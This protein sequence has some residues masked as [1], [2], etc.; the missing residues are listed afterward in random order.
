MNKKI[1]VVIILIL[2][3]LTIISLSSKEEIKEEESQDFFITLKRDN[4]ELILNLDDYVIGVVSAEMPA[5]FSSD[6]LKAQAVA[7]RTIAL[8]T[9]ENNGYVTEGLQSYLNNEE[10]KIKWQESY[11][12]YYEKIKQAVED[13]SNIVMMYDNKIIKSYYYSISN[14]YTAT[15]L[16]VFNEELP[17]LS[18]VNASLDTDNLKFSKTIA[19]TRL[20]F[21]NKLNIDCTDININNITY[22]SSK[23]VDVIT[24]NNKEFKGTTIRKLLN[25]RSTDFTIDIED[26][27]TI[28]T[29]GYGHGVGLSQYGA[30]ALA[31]IGYSYEDILKYYYQDIEI[32]KYNV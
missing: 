26:N 18:E 5:S 8:Y 31:S 12:Y 25:L 30:E 22:D 24:I 1:L 16:S 7:A 10:L 21:C 15:S 14:G 9:L 19:L 20:D 29:K 3:P 28:T 11:Q 32:T 17:Y 6:A 13:T 2:L 23:R 4:E 27:I